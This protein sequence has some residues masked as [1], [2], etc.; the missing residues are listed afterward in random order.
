MIV[1]RDLKTFFFPFDWP[2]DGDDI[3]KH[4][5]EFIIKI[6]ESLAKDKR[7]NEIE[8]LLLKYKY[9]KNIHKQENNK[10]NEPHK[11]VLNLSQKLYL[12]S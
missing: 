12:R 3:L 7:K 10:T 5:I 2:K 1:I 4:K 9:R 11:L 6:N 8:Q